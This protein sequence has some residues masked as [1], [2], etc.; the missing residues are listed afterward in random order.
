MTPGLRGSDLM[1]MTMGRVPIEE[2]THWGNYDADGHI[3]RI[4]SQVDNILSL[5]LN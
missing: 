4:Y 2:A 5:Q 1:S 3:K